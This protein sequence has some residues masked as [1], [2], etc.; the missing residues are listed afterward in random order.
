VFLTRQA[1]V[2]DNKTVI[3][4]RILRNFIAGL[5]VLGLIAL[6]FLPPQ[7]VHFTRTHDDHHPDVIHRH[8]ESFTTPKPSVHVDLVDQLAFKELPVS[9]PP[10]V[11]QWMFRAVRVSAHD[12]PWAR[13]HGLRAPPC[14]SA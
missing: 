3:K 4:G 10:P 14:L 6:A 7:H 9:P 2:A 11:F 1:R 13:P 5:S 12:P 8:F